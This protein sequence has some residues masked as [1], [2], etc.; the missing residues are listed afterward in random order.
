VQQVT[1]DGTMLAEEKAKKE[2]KD[3]EKREK[4]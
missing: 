3:K 2:K 4:Q 1:A